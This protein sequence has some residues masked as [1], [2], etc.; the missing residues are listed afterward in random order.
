MIK[1]KNTG[2]FIVD[3]SVPGTQTA[4]TNKKFFVLPFACI[5]KAIYGKL[6]TAGTTGSQ[7]NDINKNGT[8][9]FSAAA[10]Q[11][12]AST[13]VDPTYSALSV[14]PTAFVK[15]DNVS[16]DVDSIHTTAAVNLGV[17]LV[18]QRLRGTGQVAAT[19]TSGVGPENE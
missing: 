9:V 7:I 6:G 11:T 3:F 2:E 17:I 1:I 18:F 10:K 5:L 4:A 8:T 15:G 16:I 13:A 19:V 12:F 14:D